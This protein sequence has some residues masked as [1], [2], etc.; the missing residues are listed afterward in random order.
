MAHSCESP[1]DVRELLRIERLELILGDLATLRVPKERVS[2]W[3]MGPHEVH[4][5]ARRPHMTW[6]GGILREIWWVIL[7]SQ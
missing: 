7:R 2:Q 6:M 5:P 1:S 4:K 3:I